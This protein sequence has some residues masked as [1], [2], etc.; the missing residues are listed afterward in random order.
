M[1]TKYW[2]GSNDSFSTAAD[3]S[4][5]GVPASGDTAVITG[6]TPSL[7]STTLTGTTVDLLS[8]NA[9]SAGLLMVLS[10][11]GA[12]STVYVGA[13]TTDAVLTINGTVT[14]SG[15]LALVSTGSGTASLVMPGTATASGVLVNQ[16][17]LIADGAANIYTLSSASPTGLVN[18]GLFT[19]END[20]GRA[21][22][23]F[24][25]AEVSGTGAIN[26]NNGTFT[27][28]TRGVGAGQTVT[29]GAG[30]ER[31]EFDAPGQVFATF[32]GLSP[33]SSIVLT[34]VTY[35]G[36]NY[37]T[38]GA[39]SGSL[40]FLQG[41][42]VVDSVAFS[43]NYAPNSFNVGTT[44]TNGVPFTTITGTGAAPQRLAYTDTTTGAS[45]GDAATPYTGPVNYLQWQY[46]WPSN[47]G[48]AM[49]ASVDNIF[50]HGGGGADAITAH[51][52]RNVIDGGGGSNFLTGGTG[53]DGGT[54]TFFVD[55]RGGIV[56]WS[57]IVN[58]HHGDS[59]TI[60]G[61]TQGTSTLPLQDSDGAAGFTGA[62]IHSELNGA[63]TGVN[64]SVTFVGVSGAD[65][66]DVSQGGKFT[67]TYGNIGGD[68]PYLNVA[69]TG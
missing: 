41:N 29:F 50:L 40:Q 66:R 27:D 3:W 17:S 25:Q 62:T 28:F 44:T 61:F 56:T 6:G 42:T 68:T 53:A 13:S 48:V 2:N 54:D 10:T 34:G 18:N 15:A 67:Y 60:F 35:T 8:S 69:Y 32:A 46:V 21:G 36:L 30:T 11:I 7:V 20:T 1:A 39:N 4:P 24:V 49:A 9:S 47:D 64:G 37:A 58:F 51:G 63:G 19:I 65:A 22:T 38:T 45:S 33:T 43:G 31:V 16:G 59:L 57:S 23:L 14:N 5:A 12:G 26:V 55:G 52:G